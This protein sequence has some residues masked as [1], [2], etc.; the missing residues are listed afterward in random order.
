MKKIKTLIIEDHHLIADSYHNGLEKVKSQNKDIDFDIISVNT[1]D[2]ALLYINNVQKNNFDLIF[3]DI[4]LPKSKDGLVLS[5]E[6]LGVTIRE[7]IPDTKIIVT[8]TYNDNYRINNILKSINPEGFLIKNDTTP[9]DLIL[10]IKTVIDDTPYYSKTVLKLLR[11]HIVN[12]FFLDKTDRK[13]LY[14]ISIGTKTIDLPKVIPMSL[15][16]IEYRKRQLKD[17]FSVQ[18]MDDK[19]LVK[20]AKEKG[21]I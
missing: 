2:K 6:D 13:L 17:I 7:K 16:G 19:E 9:K 5:G 10:A 15:G 12:D 1:I 21:F 20:K 4:K 14:E 8:T 18:K 3:L 11:K